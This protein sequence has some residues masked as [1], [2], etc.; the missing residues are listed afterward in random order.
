[1]QLKNVCN[2]PHLIGRKRILL[3]LSWKHY[4]RFPF[5]RDSPSADS[6][7]NCLIRR[8][9]NIDIRTRELAL[10]SNRHTAENETV[11]F[12]H[13]KTITNQDQKRGRRN[14]LVLNNEWLD[15]AGIII[16]RYFCPGM[17]DNIFFRNGLSQWSNLL[18]LF[19][20]LIHKLYCMVSHCAEL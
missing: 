20:M 19:P 8:I 11:P 3:P 18:K 5:C 13:I 17:D 9:M 7:W 12:E 16:M 14:L 10:L 1:M 6:R 4:N 15:G 2:H